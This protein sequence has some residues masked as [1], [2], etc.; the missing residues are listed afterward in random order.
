[1]QREDRK[2]QIEQPIWEL[3]SK[4][5]IISNTQGPSLDGQ[6]MD[7][8]L[9]QG[10]FSTTAFSSQRVTKCCHILLRSSP[11]QSERFLLHTRVYLF[12]VSALQR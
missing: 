4:P 5:L 8:K 6:E 12:G 3:H 11:C 1:M 7:Q 9:G 10:S 2:D